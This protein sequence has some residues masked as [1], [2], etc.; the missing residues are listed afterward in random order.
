MAAVMQGIAE[1]GGDTAIVLAAVGE[2][3]GDVVGEDR[4]RRA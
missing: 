2:V 1:N 3:V 4:V